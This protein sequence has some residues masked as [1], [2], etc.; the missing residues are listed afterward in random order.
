LNCFGAFGLFLRAFVLPMSHLASNAYLYNRPNI[1]FRATNNR[2]ETVSLPT[3][4]VVQAF[5]ADIA[6]PQLFPNQP[7][8]WHGFTPSFFFSQMGV[9]PFP[10][11]GNV[12]FPQASQIPSWEEE[13]KNGCFPKN[14]VVVFSGQLALLVN[15]LGSPPGVFKT[16]FVPV[17]N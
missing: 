2:V 3:P 6:A 11:A 17:V 13:E 12:S 16:F 1:P 9:K 15:V 7:V 4:V 8:F 5:P 14:N 10:P